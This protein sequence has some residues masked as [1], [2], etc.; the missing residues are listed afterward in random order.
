MRVLYAVLAAAVV[1]MCIMSFHQ[2]QPAYSVKTAAIY[3]AEA[4]AHGTMLQL[5]CTPQQAT[6][7]QH[8]QEGWETL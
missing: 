7:H 4:A 5:Q 3:G 2:H 1:L 6:A 8:V